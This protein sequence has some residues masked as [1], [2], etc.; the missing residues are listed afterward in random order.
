MSGHDD[1]ILDF[2]FFDEPATVEQQ[3]TQRVRMPR[4]RSGG[5][6]DGPPRQP[7]RPPQGFAPL[8]RLAGLIAFAIAL[9]VLLVFWVQS[10]QDTAKK[11][12]YRHYVEDA[13]QV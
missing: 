9:V 7:I 6:D 2:D 8:F 4:R 11:N 13:S 1:D 5:G 12:S 3:S 10:C